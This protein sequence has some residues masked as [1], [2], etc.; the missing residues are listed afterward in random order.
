MRDMKITGIIQTAN[1][2]ITSVQ[3]AQVVSN[4]VLFYEQIICFL[5]KISV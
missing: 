5:C 3:R 1:L 2:T 4:Y